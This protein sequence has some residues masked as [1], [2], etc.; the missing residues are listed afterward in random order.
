MA[1]T[2][3]ITV[4]TVVRGRRCGKQTATV[5]NR[6]GRSV[7]VAWHGSCVEDELDVDEVEVWPD[8]PAD[9]SEWHGG[10]GVIDPTSQSFEVRPSR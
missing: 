2:Q 6:K 4:G 8:A 3:F 7:F 5:V 10:V 1:P 9:L